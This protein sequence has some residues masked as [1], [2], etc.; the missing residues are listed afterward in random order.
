MTISS[1]GSPALVAP[2]QPSAGP[3][4]P[5]LRVEEFA[6]DGGEGTGPRPVTVDDFFV[7]WQLGVGAGA[8]R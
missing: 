5:I 6:D 4:R 8:R 3:D 1:P 2:D 7:D